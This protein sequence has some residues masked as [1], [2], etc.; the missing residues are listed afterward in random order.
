[1]YNLFRP[2]S[3]FALAQ[4]LAAP[5]NAWAAAM[6]GFWTHPS[7][8]A[9]GTAMGRALGAAA[10]LVERA[11][12]RY[13]KPAFDLHTTV[14]DGETVGV[15]ETR[16]VHTPFCDLLRFERDGAR[17]DPKVLVVAP[18]SG[19][20]ASLVRDTVAALLPDHDI[21]LTDWIDARLVPA[22]DGAFDLDDYID[23][24]IR[25]VRTIGPRLNLVAVCQ[26]AVPAL[27]A[28]ALLA[29]DSDA[30]VPQT[31]TLMGG[32]V[33]TRQN[34][35]APGRLAE[36]R[37]LGWFEA[38]LVHD[39]PPGE[40][41]FGRRVYPGFL[42]LS[43]FLAMNHRRHA[44]AHA[45]LYRHLV[46]GDEHSAQAHRRFY[47]DYLAVMDLPAEY[48]LQ[49]VATV[50]QRHDLPR[51]AMRHRGVRPVRPA[52]VRTTALMTIEGEKDDITGVGQCFAAHALCPDI[53]AERRVHHLQP[54]AG[55]Y[56][57]FSGRRWRD[58]IAPRLRDFIR[59]CG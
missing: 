17:D 59:R 4:T 38:A 40:P 57:I 22:A 32:P 21:Y 54:G 7:L 41:G 5:M 43:A 13:P 1:M 52:A 15:R 16:L 14:I 18:L 56:G 10:E 51:G 45:D 46:A 23:L 58:D 33:D 2:Y 12:R 26:P 49:T 24:L 29:E 48:Y 55:H 35:T 28:V 47:D 6:R 37:P 20:H 3:A 34:P 11:T 19:H 31:L 30:A 27:A 25:F 42:Q 8:P 9:S 36:S 50:F 44:D 53:P 39:V